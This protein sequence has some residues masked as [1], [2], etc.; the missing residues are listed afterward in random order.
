MHT[1]HAVLVRGVPGRDTPPRHEHGWVPDQN[2]HLRAGTTAVPGHHPGRPGTRGD[3]ACQDGTHPPRQHG[4]CPSTPERRP[5][6]AGVPA[7]RSLVP[8]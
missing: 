1:T 8:D 4:R 2:P 5:G 3:G 6:M 7:R